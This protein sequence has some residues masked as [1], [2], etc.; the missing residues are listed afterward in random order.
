[1]HENEPV[2][3]TYFMVSHELFRRKKDSSIRNVIIPFE[4]KVFLKTGEPFNSNI[5]IIP[6]NLV[7]N[8]LV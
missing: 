8:I 3:G 4:N 2:E 7:D 6:N 1:M 5:L